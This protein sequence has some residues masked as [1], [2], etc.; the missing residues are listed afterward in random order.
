MHLTFLDAVI[1]E[2]SRSSIH[3]NNGIETIVETRAVEER[4]LFSVRMYSTK[5]FYKYI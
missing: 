2:K 5:I 3:S 4:W 1:K